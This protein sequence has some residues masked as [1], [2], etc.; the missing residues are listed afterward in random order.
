MHAATPI[1]MIIDVLLNC[2]M[3]LSHNICNVVLQPAIVSV[4]FSTCQVR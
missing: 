4:Q 3:H 1:S 2:I